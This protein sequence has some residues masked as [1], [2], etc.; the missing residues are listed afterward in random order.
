MIHQEGPVALFCILKTM[1]TRAVWPQ[2]VIEALCE[3]LSN[4][5]PSDQLEYE[6][7][8]A[9]PFRAMTLIELFT[10]N[11]VEQQP[12][13]Y[14]MVP[15]LCNLLQVS[16]Q[17]ADAFAS[18]TLFIE[19][20]SQWLSKE[21]AID[22]ADPRRLKSLLDVLRICLNEKAIGTRIPRKLV[23]AKAISAINELTTYTQEK[24]LALFSLAQELQNRIK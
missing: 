2:M 9:Q 17:L 20:I 23:P 14:S 13:A 4:N 5:A 22:K 6:R 12:W 8:L 3:L 21:V 15:S 19:T 24:K 7:I 18:N 10:K 1:N 11:N 16:H